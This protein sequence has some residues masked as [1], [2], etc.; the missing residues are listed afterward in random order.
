MYK[1]IKSLLFLILPAV[2]VLS[3]LPCVYAQDTSA[4]SQTLVKVNITTSGGSG[5]ISGQL[6]DTAGQTSE[7][8][9]REKITGNYERGTRFVLSA[10]ETTCQFLYWKDTDS[11]RIIT[12]DKT[13]VAMVGTDISIS[14]V[15][16][17]SSTTKKLVMFQNS[18]GYIIS[19]KYVA[20]DKTVTIPSNNPSV[21]GYAFDS[22][23]LGGVS[24]EFADS[25]INVSELSG[26]SVYIAKH[27]PKPT[28]YEINI[29]G[30]S[31]SGSFVYNTKVVAELDPSAVP[32]GKQ[33]AYWS[34]GK[35]I[36][37]YDKT[38]TFYVGAN[39]NISAV[40][41][42][43]EPAQKLPTLSIVVSDINTSTNRIAF[44]AERSLPFDYELVETGILVH[45]SESFD[46]TTSGISKVKSMSKNASGQFCITKYSVSSGSVWYA[47][48]YMIYLKDGISNVIYSDTVNAT[49][50]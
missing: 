48:A 12:R 2:L 38:Y 36:L 15:F 49:L 31:G 10:N 33:F 44:L 19:S 11:G 5:Q 18:N 47:K 34:N 46:L 13:Y 27:T 9:A 21:H 28:L 4:S 32:E 43:A 14:A 26:D 8:S 30:G 40:Y 41:E 20:D 1:R 23:T 17:S 35:D 25:T 24:Q 50:N 29:T 7:I 45:T 39:A 16:R 42:D 37:S 22:W 6:I 3:M